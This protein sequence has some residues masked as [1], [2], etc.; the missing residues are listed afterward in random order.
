MLVPMDDHGYHCML[1]HLCP[2]LESMT[3]EE[4]RTIDRWWLAALNHEDP[5]FG[6][7]DYITICQEVA[8]K[9]L[10]LKDILKEV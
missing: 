6:A 4:L 3:F 1:Q 7:A 2:C 9:E 5:K 8:T 10:G